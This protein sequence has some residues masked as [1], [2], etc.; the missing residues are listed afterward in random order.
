MPARSS[1]TPSALA[2]LIGGANWEL[3]RQLGS[4]REAWDDPLYWQLGYPLLLLAAFGLGFVW[5]ERPWRWAVW[6][7]AG[8]VTWSLL[9]V[10]TQDGVPNLLPLGLIM[11]ALLGIPC[12]LAAYAGRWVGERAFA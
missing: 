7:I 10:T 6:L 1:I 4:R 11:F 2:F 8:Q 5:R 9:L 3:V 12:L